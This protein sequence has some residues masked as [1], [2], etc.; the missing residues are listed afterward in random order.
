MC[1]PCNCT[2]KYKDNCRYP[3]NN[4]GTCARCE[5]EETDD[6][7]TDDEEQAPETLPLVTR[8]ADTVDSSTV[9]SVIMLMTP[10]YVHITS[11]MITFLVSET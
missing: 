2:C 5:Q 10:S 3:H 7:S 11:Q 9:M 4:G 1:K 6:N 8:S